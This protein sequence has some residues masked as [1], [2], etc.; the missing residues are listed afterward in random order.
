MMRILS[1]VMVVFLLAACVAS[2]TQRDPLKQ[3]V[4]VSVSGP[5]MPVTRETP[6]SWYSDVISVNDDGATRDQPQ[7]SIPDWMKGEIQQQMEAKGFQFADSHT[8][9]QMVSV[10]I[11]G[12][13]D[14]SRNTQAMFRLFPT[15]QGESRQYPKGTLLLGILDS[16]TSQG[17][18]RS[19]LQTF[20]TPDASDEQKQARLKVL[21]AETL[22]SLQPGS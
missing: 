21:V 11:L 8:R 19:A 16:E 12:D 14:I 22:K 15:L 17:V 4:S 5:D 9:Y 13:G 1:V 7:G 10:M 20:A 6:L 18:W 3:K 2:P